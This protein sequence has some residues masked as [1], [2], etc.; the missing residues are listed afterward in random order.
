M[1]WLSEIIAFAAGII[2]T[3]IA[4]PL[5]RKFLI[6]SNSNRVDQSGS[7]AGGDIVGRDK[8]MRG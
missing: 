7:K 3:L 1:E 6:K 8:S 5:V 4:Q 2:S